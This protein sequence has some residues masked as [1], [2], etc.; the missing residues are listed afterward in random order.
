[1]PDNP[2]VIVPLDTR[3]EKVHDVDIPTAQKYMLVALNR[4]EKILGPL[5]RKVADITKPVDE[6]SI[7]GIYN[8]VT[9]LNE[10]T[11]FPQFDKSAERIS[12]VLVTGPPTTAFTL[13][14]G[15][16]TWNVL[17][18]ATGTWQVHGAGI[19][20][21][22]NDSRILQSATAGDWSLELCGFADERFYTP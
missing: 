1:M 9:S 7:T 2:R 4:L 10:I 5:S 22:K 11:V 18:D 13:T 17:T 20:L 3:P 21:D 12:Y 16:R 6:Y 15:N 19:M 8:Q 14:L